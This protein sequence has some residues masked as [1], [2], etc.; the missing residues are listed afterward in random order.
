MRGGTA[1]ANDAQPKPSR[2]IVRDANRSRGELDAPL[3]RRRRYG[4]VFQHDS[5]PTLLW[6]PVDGRKRL[7]RGGYRESVR[8]QRAQRDSSRGNLAEER[9]DVSLLGES[10]VGQW[11]V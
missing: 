4:R 9:L 5:D 6:R 2:R 3:L 1:G 7:G 10:H 11:V 8:D